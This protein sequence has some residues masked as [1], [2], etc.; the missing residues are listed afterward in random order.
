MSVA[1]HTS[2]EML[3]RYAAGKLRPAPALVVASHLAISPSSR[4]LAARFESIGGALLEHEPLADLSPDLFER[5]LGRLDAS[6][7]GANAPGSMP[8]HDAL[9][10][11]IALPPP[12]ARRAIGPWRWLGPGLHCARI[13][14]AEDSDHNLVL[15]R[16]Q[17]GVTLPEHGHA[18]EELSLV[19]KGS[20][21]DASGRYVVG[22]LTVEDQD[23]GHKPV[24]T[25]DGECICLLAIEGRMRFKSWMARMAQPWTGL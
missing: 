16:G 15:L 21:Q 24:V 13:S 23:S 19:L 4:R 11:G 5:T 12:L 14:M 10:M 1:N 2:E 8:N 22:D 6:S 9:D 17:A 7:A 18:G 3:L 20:F 25:E